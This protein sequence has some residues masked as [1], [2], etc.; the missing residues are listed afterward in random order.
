MKKS[1]LGLIILVA[2]FALIGMFEEDTPNDGREAPS[3]NAMAAWHKLT[4][5]EG[6]AGMRAASRPHIRYV[7]WSDPQGLFSAEVPRGWRVE[8][9][10]NPQGLDKGAFMIQGFSPDG[11]SMFSFAHNW[12]W[13]MEYQY[14]P[15]RPGAATLESFVVPKLPEN[16]PQMRL[17]D[18]R[19]VYRGAD[20][21][22]QLTNP[23]TGMALR[24]DQGTLGLLAMR[25]GG[26]VLAGTLTGETLYIPTPGSPGLW[27]LR[28]FSGGIAPATSGDQAGIQEIQMHLVQ[29]LKLSQE[30]RQAW[31][32]AH[33][34][35]MENM[36][37]YSRDMGRVF[38]SY[39][40]SA[41]R[42]NAGNR[43][44]PMEGWAEMMR[45]GHY[46]HNEE[47]GEEYWVGNN[48]RYWWTDD[49]GDVVGN[50]TGA[51]PANDENWHVLTR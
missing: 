26:E 15:Y 41:G 11:R 1:L 18:V 44:D 12:L 34:H 50:N 5:G 7:R 49:R 38:D 45:E 42:S 30:F 43:K 13:F 22:S 10:V 20:R 39:L 28:I 8:G 51:P 47:T 9:Q 24:A 46:E 32:N 19:I 25:A 37:Q 31:A 14:G 27:G 3:G 35:T 2:V 48:D 33:R 6:Q 23:T 29:T 17:R 21:H 4:T 36:R 40:A 16:V